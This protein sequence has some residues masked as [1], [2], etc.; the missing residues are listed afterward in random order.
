[1]N[2]RPTYPLT[3]VERRHLNSG[4]PDLK[5]TYHLVLDLSATLIEYKVGDCL[6]IFPHN[7]NDLVDKFLNLLPFHRDT[8]LL[9]Q[10]ERISLKD[11]LTLHVNLVKCSR[12]LI[13]WSGVD[14]SAHP[15][16]VFL[17]ADLSK[18]TLEILPTLF[19]KQLPRFY[20]I[21][22]S[23]KAVGKQAHLI[24]ALA[25]NPEGSATEYGTCSE[26]LCKTAPLNS[27]VISAYHHPAPHFFLPLSTDTPIIMIGP[28]T[29]VAPFR[30]FMQERSQVSHCNKNW[31]FFGEKRE[32]Y[33]FFYKNEWEQWTR[34][35]QLKLAT[36]FSRDSDEKVYVQH[37]MLEHSKD[38]WNW[39]EQG[40]HLYI[41]GD[42]KQ[43]AKAVD[44]ALREIIQREG[45]LSPMDAILYLKKLRSEKRYQRDVY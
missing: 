12:A 26:F 31:L 20:S 38:I 1:M 10:E 13:E 24:V 37:R 11:F 39:L 21:S 3:I 30:G 2:R 23:M 44:E 4:S 34:R 5:E 19:S 7:S 22:S 17:N 32:A 42:A 8:T 29:G 9:Y 35:G 41:C 6:A 28:G 16:E 33:D 45:R 36:A 14:T 18:L 40:A 43:M 27:P 25:K 15:L